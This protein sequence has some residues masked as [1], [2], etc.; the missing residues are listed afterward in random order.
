MCSSSRLRVYVS[1]YTVKMLVVRAVVV[2]IARLLRI[3]N[4]VLLR[5]LKAAVE[6][7]SFICAENEDVKNAAFFSMFT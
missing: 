3:A 6:I 4:V 5:G 1:S 2:A 7:F